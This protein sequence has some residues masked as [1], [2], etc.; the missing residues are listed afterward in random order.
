M[1]G[2]LEQA[3]LRLLVP[4]R[5]ETRFGLDSP[6]VR[7]G[8]ASD[9]EVSLSDLSLSREHAQIA[10]RG[11]RYRLRDLGSR[12]GTF[13]NDAK[14]EGEVLLNDG[15]LIRVGEMRLQ[16]H[17]ETPS[18]VHL[19]EASRVL[20]QGTVSI[21]A[22]DIISGSVS[23]INGADDRRLFEAVARASRALFAKAS[24][25]EVCGYVLGESMNALAGERGVVMLRE[26]DPPTLR[27]RSRH[28]D[29]EL[30]LSRSIASKVIEEGTSLL[31][32]D[33]QIDPR[34]DASNSIQIQGIRS[35]VC[36]PLWHEE[37]ISGLL[38][39][40]R[41]FS[42]KPFK[43]I[44][45]ALL[46]VLAN[47]AAAKLDNLRLTEEAQEKRS[48][49]EELALAAEIQ[50]N[51]L[52]AAEPRFAGWEFAGRSFPSRS[53][54]GDLYDYIPLGPDRLGVVVAD[55]SGKGTS[56]ALLM[57]SLQANLRA[58]LA[59]ASDLAEAMASVN[60]A[61]A[62]TTTRNKFA[63]VFLADLGAGQGGFRYV[64]GGHTPGLIVRK[65]GTIERLT[66]G[67][68]IVGAFADLAT[69]EVGHADLAAS[70]LLVLYSDGITEAEGA[71]QAMLGVDGLEA[72]LRSAPRDSAAAVRDAVLDAIHEYTEGR[73]PGDDTTLVV[74]RRLPLG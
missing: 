58:Y 67:G 66:V 50:R 7:I 23:A 62:R 25:D 55:V 13:L 36:V 22:E 18:G 21:R 74:A 69:Y 49:D 15:D 44:D 24:V 72:I 39:V 34:F 61:L 51:S 41:R 30:E 16:F 17:H 5:E 54:G 60:Q 28:G 63:T 12:N 19:S 26:G 70:D 14:V 71:D 20:D 37:R 42:A 35:A 8:R 1:A 65:N 40:D 52:P 9:N 32:N 45:L 57:A 11:N 64:N 56:A 47:L 10:R 31:T 59:R 38:Y 43:K 73:P 27:A 48:L 3:Y 53:V 2:A 46:T 68:M 29:G 4:G 33:A 6:K